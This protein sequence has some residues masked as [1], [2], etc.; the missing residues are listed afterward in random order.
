MIGFI[1]ALLYI[2]PLLVISGSAVASVYSAKAAKECGIRT[3]GDALF[4]FVCGLVP[5]VNLLFVLAGVYML[6]IEPWWAEA[7]DQYLHRLLHE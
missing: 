1:L 3:R 7:K 4:I 5:V 2:I 6:H